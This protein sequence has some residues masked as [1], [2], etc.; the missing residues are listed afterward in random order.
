MGIPQLDVD[1]PRPWAMYRG[2][3]NINGAEVIIGSLAKTSRISSSHSEAAV[4]R[5]S[6]QSHPWL[7]LCLVPGMQE[8]HGFWWNLH[9][10][11]QK[12]HPKVPRQ[13][14][15]PCTFWSPSSQAFC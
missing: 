2:E 1:L 15:D 6:G 8:T 11:A 10:P 12:H 3:A 13:E 7:W 14:Q 5:S 9:A 4:F